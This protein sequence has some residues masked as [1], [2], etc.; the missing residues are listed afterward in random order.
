[1]RFTRR[2]REVILVDAG[3]DDNT[4]AVARGFTGVRM[5]HD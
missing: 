2:P 4:A 5:L 1:M 3:S